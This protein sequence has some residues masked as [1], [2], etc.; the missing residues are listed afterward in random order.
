[1]NRL[2]TYIKNQ[3]LF[4]FAVDYED[5]E[6]TGI[7][8]RRSDELVLFRMY[9]DFRDT[10]FS[11]M[12]IDAL[13]GVD[14]D[15]RSEAFFD[16]V[17]DRE[18]LKQFDTH[19]DHTQLNLTDWAHFFESIIECETLVQITTPYVNDL[20]PHFFVG[21]FISCSDDHLYMRELDAAGEWHSS[22]TR[23]DFV[24]VMDVEFDTHYGNMFLKY[25][26]PLY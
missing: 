23:I 10:G 7:A 2:D 20:D 19:I 26:N 6:H 12:R 16:T 9:H 22:L 5:V 17:F 24:D 18:G 15:P 3:T 8:L 4:T 1:M 13:M 11:V 25:A 21:K 14:K